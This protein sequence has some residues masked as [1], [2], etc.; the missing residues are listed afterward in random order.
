MSQLYNVCFTIFDEIDAFMARFASNDDDFE[1]ISYMVFQQE[2]CPESERLHIQGYCELKKK[3]SFSAIKE[4]FKNYTMHIENR[5]GSQQE[6][7]DYC[8]KDESRV[9]GPYEWGILKKQGKRNDIVE[10]KAILEETDSLY[11]VMMHNPSA[12][13]KYHKGFSA[14]QS[15]IHEE[16]ENN[17]EYKLPETTV[18]I[19]PSGCGKTKFVHDRHQKKDIFILNQSNSKNVWWCGYRQ[20]KVLLIDEFNGWLNFDYLLRL[21]DGYGMKLEIKGGHTYANWDY[22]YITS[23]DEVGDWYLGRNLDPLLR[24]IK[25]VGHLESI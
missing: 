24:R 12:F 2:K 22:I 10:C 14:M 1:N 23:N 11:H 19:G 4:C 5:R 3:M 20:H 7:V 21:L 13:I 6:A 15:L 25:L 8:K 18:L 16:R 17:K 9:D